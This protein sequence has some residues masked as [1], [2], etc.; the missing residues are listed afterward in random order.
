MISERDVI[1]ITKKQASIAVVAL[2]VFCILI[3]MLG[4]FWGKQSVLDGFGQRIVQDPMSEPVDYDSM[5]PSFG[6]NSRQY[7]SQVQDIPCEHGSDI[8]S[9]DHDALDAL[10]DISIVQESCGNS[11]K[12]D[13]VAPVCEV[14]NG[15]KTNKKITAYLF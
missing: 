6:D 4:Y 1:Y 8:D 2:A 14:K 10:R 11:I 7:E 12:E 13:V 3:F 9:Y 15:Q 5:I